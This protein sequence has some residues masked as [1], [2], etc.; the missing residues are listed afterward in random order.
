MKIVVRGTNWVG[1]AVMTIPALREL[2]RVFPDSHI[3]LH[4]RDWARGIFEDADF[5]D[6]I[7]TFEQGKSALKTVLEQ[8][9]VL[10]GRKFDAAVL[11]PN[12]F[13]SALTA[14]LGQIKTRIGYAKDGRSFLLTDALPIPEW[15]NQRHEVFYYLNIVAEIEKKLRGATTVWEHEPRFELGVSAERKTRACKMLAESGV[16]LS[17]KIVVF[18]AG[19]TNSRAKRWQ[20]KS[21]AELNDRIQARLNANVVLIGS[22]DELD[23]SIEVAAKSNIKPSILTGKTDLAEATA[24]L[25]VCDLVIS[26]DTGPAHIAAALGTKTLIIFGPTNPLTTRPFPA[27]AEIIYK[28]VE[29]SPCMLRDCPIDHRCMTRIRADEVFIKAENLLTADKRR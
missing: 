20:T 8:G 7:L 13:E 9:K 2:R 27:N 19:S 5:I 16:D 24:I 17:K 18:V 14:K 25:S 12:S 22:K 11:L 26:N 28:T 29:C 15:K 23:V 1:D 4:T 10:R 21:F 6:E 3:A